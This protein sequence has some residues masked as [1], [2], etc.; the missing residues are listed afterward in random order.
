MVL[1]SKPAVMPGSEAFDPELCRITGRGRNTAMILLDQMDSRPIYEQIAEKLSDLML[2]GILSENTPLPSV[3]S[4][5]A[6]LSINPNT[7]QRAYIELERMGCIYSVKGKGSFVAAIDG[8][9]TRRC[10]ELKA[11]VRADIEKARQAGVTEDE[12]TA[13]VRNVYSGGIKT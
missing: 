3:R 8:L 11:L 6:E 12:L 1:Y 7:V 9:K 5:A 10:D 13:V 4:L 2:K